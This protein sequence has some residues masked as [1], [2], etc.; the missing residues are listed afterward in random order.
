MPYL[1][2]RGWGRLE[3]EAGSSVTL[4]WIGPR[5]GGD[6]APAA[7]GAGKFAQKFLPLSSQARTLVWPT[8]VC[9]VPRE[10]KP[11]GDLTP[12]D[13]GPG[14]REDGRQAHEE[15]RSGVSAGLVAWDLPRR[16]SSSPGC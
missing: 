10:P 8:E 4:G 9:V 15:V 13:V 6:R 16:P 1:S 3:T 11:R 2:E 7:L 5:G 14:L 12:Q